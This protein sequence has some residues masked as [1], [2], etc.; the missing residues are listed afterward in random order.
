MRSVPKGVTTDC[1]SS[2]HCTPRK[3]HNFPC[4]T[5]QWSLEATLSASKTNSTT[6]KSRMSRKCLQRRN[7]A[8]PGHLSNLVP[9]PGER[10]QYNYIKSLLAKQHGLATQSLI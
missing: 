5:Q 2:H 7:R 9:W 8:Q 1:M 6:S 4:F 10:G 3:G